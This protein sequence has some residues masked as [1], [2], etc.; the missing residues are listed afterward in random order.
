[1][2]IVPRVS[3]I[4]PKTIDGKLILSKRANKEPFPN[5]W[6]CAIGGKAKKW[7]TYEQAGKRETQEEAKLKI[8]IIEKGRFY[9]YHPD[10][11]ANYCVFGTREPVSINALTPDPREIQ[12]FQAFYESEIKER[13]NQN[14]KDFAPTFLESFRVFIEN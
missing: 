7:E 8:E 1:M 6:V 11:E 2:G 9:Y 14:K 10:F 3:L 5:T 13:I 4:I 12:Y